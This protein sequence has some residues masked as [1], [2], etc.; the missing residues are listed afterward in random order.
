MVAVVLGEAHPVV[1]GEGGSV[2]DH[3][4]QHAGVASAAAGPAAEG[5]HDGRGQPAPPMALVDGHRHHAQPAVDDDASGDGG[6]RSRG[7]V[8][9]DGGEDRLLRVEQHI[10]VDRGQRGARYR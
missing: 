6:Q 8:E 9:A 7:R 1:E 2:D 10:A 5:G 4:L 3:H